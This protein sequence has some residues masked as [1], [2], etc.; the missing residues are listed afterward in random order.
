MNRKLITKT[1]LQTMKTNT[2][3]EK[4]SRQWWFFL[5]IVLV[6]FVIMPVA[7]RN[8][9]FQQIQSII[10]TNLTKALIFKLT[11]LY[12]YFQLLSFLLIGGLFLLRN[13]FRGIFSLYV[14]ISYLAFAILQNIAITEK[15]G[16][17]MVTINIL[18]FSGI[19]CIWLWETLHPKTN[20]SFRNLNWK[21]YWM[22][23]LALLAFWTPLNMKTLEFSFTGNAFLNN[24][25]ALTFCMMTP[26][27]LTIQTLCMPQA[28]RV[29]YRMTAFIGILLGLYN[30]PA[31]FNPYTVNLGILHLPLLFISLF[32]FIY[33]FTCKTTNTK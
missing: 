2:I 32:S 9:D 20:Y 1:N 16:F 28:N 6:Q 31:L 25:S 22:I 4:T 24:G 13:R 18:M 21:T 29:A 12:P 8:F 23:P 11:A 7:T 5:L 17:S 30:L 19:S 26:I 3:L 10:S 33:S 27:F 14:T 15:Y